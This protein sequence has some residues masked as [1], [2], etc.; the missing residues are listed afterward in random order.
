MANAICAARSNYFKVKDEAAFLAWADSRGLYRSTGGDGMWMIG[1]AADDGA[2]PTSTWDEEADE[3]QHV[4][5]QAE[6][7][8]HLADGEI[9]VLIEAGFEKLRYVF[10]FA[11]AFDNTGKAV[12]VSLLNIYTLAEEAFGKRPTPAEY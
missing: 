3:E 8:E 7:C 9:C 2:W 1:G 12:Q 6:L 4:D 5:I 10:G 11:S